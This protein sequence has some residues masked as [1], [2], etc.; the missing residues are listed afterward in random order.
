MENKNMRS[1]FMLRASRRRIVFSLLLMLNMLLV[2]C[3]NE[4]TIEKDP[5]NT[6]PGAVAETPD[7]SGNERNDRETSATGYFSEKNF[8]RID[9]STATIPLSEGIASKL[10]NMKPEEVSKIV[11]HNKTHAAYTKLIQGDAD[12]IFVT[13]P[14]KEELEMAKGNNV[15]LEVV[16]VVKDAFVFLANKKNKIESLTIKQIQYIYSGKITNWKEVGAEDGKILAYQRPLNS[17]SQTLMLNMVMKDIPMVTPEKHMEPAGMGDLIEVVAGYDNSEFALGY[18]VY[19]YASSM[20]SRDT[21]K[22]IGVEGVKP[23]HSTIKSGQYPLTSAYYAV[24]RKSE[25]EDS[26]ARELLKYILSE[27]GQKVAEKSGYVPLR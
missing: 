13:E 15:E 23:E 8:K 17:G 12:I 9:G 19:Y 16:P 5:I 2:G 27:Q 26:F 4:K 10:L 11:T 22:L 6:T 20:Y 3:K 25:S 18:S 14:S 1:V 24:I 21:V 7:P